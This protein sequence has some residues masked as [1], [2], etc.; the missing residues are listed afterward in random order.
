VRIKDLEEAMRCQHC[1]VQKLQESATEQLQLSQANLPISPA[2]ATEAAYTACSTERTFTTETRDTDEDVAKSKHM[3]SNPAVLHEVVSS[4]TQDMKRCMVQ[5]QEA[6]ETR[7]KQLQSGI[8]ELWMDKSMRECAAQ[9]WEEKA[10]REM[11]AALSS[12]EGNSKLLHQMNERVVCLESGDHISK[13][14]ITFAD[15]QNNVSPPHT[16]T[17][18]AMQSAKT[19]GHHSLDANALRSDSRASDKSTSREMCS[20]QEVGPKSF[21]TC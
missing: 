17:S 15:L 8:D 5:H 4:M 11:N 18:T 9:A 16:S 12:M 10:A 13:Q 6:S 7:F 19:A 21:R 2:C 20:W 1:M 14:N 3:L